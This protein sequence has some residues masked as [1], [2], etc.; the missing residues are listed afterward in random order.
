MDFNEGYF[1]T[2]SRSEPVQNLLTGIAQEIA[3]T[4]REDAPVDTKAYKNGIHVEGKFQQR[5]VALVVAGDKKSLIIEAKKHVL[6]RA[7]NKH[8]RARRG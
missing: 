8:K 3:E 2:L 6:L 7:L 1:Q 4:A 5:A